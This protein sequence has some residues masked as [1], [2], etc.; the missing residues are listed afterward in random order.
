MRAVRGHEGLLGGGRWRE[1]TLA[2]ASEHCRLR[3][4]RSARFS[5]QQ[6]R[7]A[8]DPSFAPNRGA[9]IP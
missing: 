2:L 9:A 8:A 1:Y 6:L 4:K 5:L 3:R 7:G